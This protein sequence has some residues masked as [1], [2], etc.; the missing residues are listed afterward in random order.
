MIFHV[1]NSERNISS[2]YITACLWMN[3]NGSRG[4]KIILKKNS[5]I[6]KIW[7]HSQHLLTLSLP[8][9]QGLRAS[10]IPNFWKLKDCRT[11][12]LSLTICHGHPGSWYYLGGWPYPASCLTSLIYYRTLSFFDFGVLKIAKVFFSP[13]KIQNHSGTCSHRF[14]IVKF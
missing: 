11:D 3:I 5:I 13:F 1:R 7:I 12:R 6:G 2:S 8:E 10:Q 9:G 14:D 4:Q